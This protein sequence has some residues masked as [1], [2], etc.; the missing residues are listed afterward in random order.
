VAFLNW[1]RRLLLDNSIAGR[2]AEPVDVVAHTSDCSVL[3]VATSTAAFSVL[4][5]EL[6][7]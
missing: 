6:R 2:V 4:M 3:S 7:C 5:I 1:C